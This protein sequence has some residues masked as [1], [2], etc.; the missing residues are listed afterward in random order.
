LDSHPLRAVPMDRA[1][2]PPAT[3]D[4]A[5]HLHGCTARPHPAT[6]AMVLRPDRTAVVLATVRG[7]TTGVVDTTQVPTAVGETPRVPQVPTA[8]V[9]VG[10]DRRHVLLPAATP[11]DAEKSVGS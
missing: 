2:R 11:T 10:P 4:T 8:A 3:R 6:G 7:L 1:P 9:P 5:T